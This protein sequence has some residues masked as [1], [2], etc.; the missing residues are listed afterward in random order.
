MISPKLSP[1]T[2]PSYSLI[3]CQNYR[4]RLGDLRS[5]QEELE[6]STSLLEDEL[7]EEKR[8][9]S[10]LQQA[11]DEGESSCVITS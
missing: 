6:S 4:K 1:P 2:H 7:N 3:L 8:N 9:G 11:I 5:R 10:R